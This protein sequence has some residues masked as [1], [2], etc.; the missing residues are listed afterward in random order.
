[1]ETNIRRRVL[2]ITRNMIPV[3]GLSVMGGGLR[4]WSL[5]EALRRCGHDVVYSVPRSLLPEGE[6]DET[7]RRLAF[8][9][10]D[11]NSII[12][13]AEPDVVLVEQWDILTYMPRISL[14]LVVDLHGSL[15]LENAFRQHRSLVSNAAAKIKALNK[16]DLVV[17]PSR[18]QQAYFMAWMMMT[19]VDP[20]QIPVEVVPLSLPLDPLPREAAME[21]ELQL[22]Y[23][24]NL[25]PW[26]DSRLALRTA[27]HVLE[28][29]GAGTLSLFVAAPNSHHC[30]KHDRK[31]EIS[32]DAL[33]DEVSRSKRVTVEG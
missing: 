29:K 1:M 6:C 27:T 10:D 12:L 7:L 28:Q 25:W 16:V 14:P 3:P 19:G 18:R 24:G 33:S 4:A 13:K 17:C 26:I 31:V 21:G 32:A 15:M 9:V 5:G 30:F 23:G 20:R 8:E 22:I 2:V 11:L